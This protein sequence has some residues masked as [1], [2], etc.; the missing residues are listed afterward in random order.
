MK[1]KVP[2]ITTLKVL[3]SVQY[4]VFIILN[5]LELTKI[6]L[7]QVSEVTRDKPSYFVQDVT[8]YIWK[9]KLF[10]YCN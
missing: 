1:K 7:K 3:N 2:E 10:L 6:V 9:G 5:Q 4:H 8:N